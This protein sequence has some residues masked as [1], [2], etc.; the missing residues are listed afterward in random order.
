[1]KG[2]Y[3]EL[4]GYVDRDMNGYEGVHGGNGF[5]DHNAEGE[6]IL[7]FATCLVIANTV[8]TKDFL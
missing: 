3:G 8:F 2:K 6:A 7:E 1:M 5:G 4:N